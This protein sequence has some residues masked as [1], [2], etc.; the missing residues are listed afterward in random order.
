MICW[1]PTAPAILGA[2]NRTSPLMM[3]GNSDDRRIATAS[4]RALRARSRLR[5]MIVRKTTY[6]IKNAASF[7]PTATTEMNQAQIAK[8]A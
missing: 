7:V 2:P 5:R 3:I 8:S 6:W 4:G 1:K